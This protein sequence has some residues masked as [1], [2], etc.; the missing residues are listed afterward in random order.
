MKSIFTKRALLV[1]LIAG[2]GV[3]A[4]S[5]YA[6]NVGAADGKSGCDMRHGQAMQATMGERRDARMAE[7][8]EKLKLAPGQAAAWQT[9]TEAEKPKPH[10]QGGNRQAMREA[11]AKMNTPQRLDAMQEKA[12]LRRAHRVARANAVKAFYV[13]LMPEQQAVFDAEAMTLFGHGHGAGHGHH[14]H[15]HQQS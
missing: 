14:G 15:M 9:F 3:L 7:L 2:S 6:M 4:A 1:A 10:P 13:Q 8:K 12:D 11:Y 5:A